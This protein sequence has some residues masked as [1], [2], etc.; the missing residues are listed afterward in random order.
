MASARSQTLFLTGCAS[1]GAVALFIG[2]AGM[3]VGDERLIAAGG[4]LGIGLAAGLGF[5]GARSGRTAPL[6]AALWFAAVP[7]AFA[8]FAWLSILG[9]NWQPGAFFT[10][11]AAAGFSVCYAG[12]VFGRRALR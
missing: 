10:G 2:F 8:A 7:G 11:I 6:D 1:S 12:G 3:L 9:G 5:L 4:A